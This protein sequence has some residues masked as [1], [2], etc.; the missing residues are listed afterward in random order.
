MFQNFIFINKVPPEPRAPPLLR[1][2]VRICMSLARVLMQSTVDRSHVFILIKCKNVMEGNEFPPN[3][4]FGY[5]SHKNGNFKFF[6]I[7]WISHCCFWCSTMSVNYIICNT[8][9]VVLTS[10]FLR[11][12]LSVIFND[13]FGTLYVSGCQPF[14]SRDPIQKNDIVAQP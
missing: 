4:T 13:I 6:L 7:Y 9:W 10:A 8:V 1:H 3:C 2:W 5:K 11:C 12:K 14:S